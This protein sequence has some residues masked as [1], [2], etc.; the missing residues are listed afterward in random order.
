MGIILISFGAYQRIFHWK[1][2][3]KLSLE[4]ETLDVDPFFI[5]NVTCSSS[6]IKTA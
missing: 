6:S 4:T 3:Y 5:I 2:S 1:Y